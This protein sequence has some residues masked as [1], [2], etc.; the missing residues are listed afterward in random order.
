MSKI[1]QTVVAFA[2]TAGGTLIIGVRDKSQNV[3]GL[4]DPL[5]DEER[6]SNAFAD[7]ISPLMIPDIRICSF[8]E[9]SVIIVSVPHAVGPYFIRSEGQEQGV[10]VRLGSTN[11][12]ADLDMTE[13]IR[14]LARNVTFDEQPC[15]ETNS[16]GIDFRAASEFFDSLAHKLTP[17]IMKSLGLIVKH[18]DSESPSIGSIL[19]FGINRRLFFPDAVIR[20]ARFQGTDTNRFIDQMEIDEYLPKAVETVISFIE[21]HTL[22]GSE[23]GRVRRLDVAEYPIKAVREAVINAIVHAD[24]SIKG[25]NIKVAIFDN[26]IEITNPGT[27]PF[28]L[29][30][31]NALTGM[32]KLR[33]RIVGRVFRELKLIEQWG[34]GINRMISECQKHGLQEPRFEEIGTSFRV[35]LFSLPLTTTNTPEWHTIFIE[36]LTEKQ[37]IT[38]KDAALLWSLSDRS[39]RTRLRKLQEQGYITEVGTSPNDPKKV[40]ILS[41]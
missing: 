9:R 36:Y 30:L 14:R 22:Q 1:V 21:R 28:G 18:G 27:L 24:Y 35:T 20:C 2:N 7:G 15:L 39:A 4:D 40:Y 12:R 37:E 41:R 17:T 16:E 25:M 13:S 19:L 11:R 23:I 26:R 38:T 5:K 6:L 8:R 34:T 33:N 32:S 31:E 3:I 10:Y 29:T